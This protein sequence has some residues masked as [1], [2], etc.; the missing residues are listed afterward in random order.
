MGVWIKI[1]C[2]FCGVCV[3]IV[4]V[5]FGYYLVNGSVWVIKDDKFME[6]C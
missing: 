2:G 3:I 5:W 6:G 4:V 1:G